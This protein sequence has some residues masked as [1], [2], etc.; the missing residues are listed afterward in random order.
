[1]GPISRWAVDKPK[2]A[3]LAWLAMAAG[4]FFLAANFGGQYNNS[5]SLPNTESAE[6]QELLEQE[7]AIPR[8]G[9]TEEIADTCTFLASERAAYVTG[10]TLHVSGGYY[11]P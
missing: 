5:F 9:R 4:I 7:L 8:L 10:Q 1:M 11:M 3:I 2:T 6:A